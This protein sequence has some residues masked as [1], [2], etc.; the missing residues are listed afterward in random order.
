MLEDQREE[1][2]FLLNSSKASSFSAK[3]MRLD[4]PFDFKKCFSRG[5]RLSSPAFIIHYLE[6]DLTH[7][8][9]GI[10]IAKKKVK[11]A[12]DRNKIKRVARE[13]FRRKGFDGFDIILVLRNE[14]NY[15]HSKCY[16]QINEIFS[17][18]KIK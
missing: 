1:N 14:K 6:N 4:K 7:G 13:V 9:L 10:R 18:L 11:K 8:R 15:K 3:R 5:K 2:A 12:V 16:E 17:N